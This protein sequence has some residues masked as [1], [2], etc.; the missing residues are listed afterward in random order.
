M[1]DEAEHCDT[2]AVFGPEEGIEGGDGARHFHYQP[3]LSVALGG[4]LW[5]LT[6]EVFA[7]RP[8]CINRRR[9]D[10]FEVSLREGFAAVRIIPLV[11]G[12]GELGEGV[13][14]TLD[15]VHVAVPLRSAHQRYQKIE[16]LVDRGS[17]KW[18]AVLACR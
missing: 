17:V 3:W 2:L 11:N 16:V 1:H 8:R 12:D 9:E 13:G 4:P 7:S 14:E 18:L 5:A 10:G 6:E 15:A